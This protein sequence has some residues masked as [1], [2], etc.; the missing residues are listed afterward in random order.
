MYFAVLFSTL[1]AFA[2]FPAIGQT[3]CTQ[4]LLQ[5][6]VSLLNS[7]DYST[8]VYLHSIDEEQFNKIKQNATANVPGYF[9]G[10]WDNF[11]E[12][13][14]KVAELT[15]YTATV[16]QSRS[17]LTNIGLPGATE[18]W[19]G[20]VKEN[21]G[22]SAFYGSFTGDLKGNNFVVHVNWKAA[23]GGGEKPIKIL[24]SNIPKLRRNTLLSI[25]ESNYVV[26]RKNPKDDLLLTATGKSG[27]LNH[28]LV[29]YIPVYV[30]VKLP[31][32]VPYNQLGSC[33]GYGGLL[34]VQLWGPVGS[35]C[36]GIPTPPWGKYLTDTSTP[37]PKRI[38]SCILHGGGEGVRVWGPEGLPCGGITSPGWLTYGAPFEDLS[39]VNI[40]GCVG[41]GG[42]EGL[43]LWGPKDASCG[44]IPTWGKHDQYCV[45]PK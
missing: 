45:A 27:T 42:V 12:E 22:A 20:C 13:R 38:G 15:K 18:A 41:H 37:K 1:F 40:C 2:A 6:N 7:Y 33:T 25:G 5:R 34:G 31:K 39:T 4:V 8:V 29:I 3:D 11:Q 43:V 36:A 24:S 21:S 19:L 26:K 28:S 10:T 30:E 16:E 9:A 23:T 35:N 14:K 17:A 44:G 32:P